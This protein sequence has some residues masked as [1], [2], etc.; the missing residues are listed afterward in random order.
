MRGWGLGCGAESCRSRVSVVGCKVFGFG[1]GVQ[2]QGLGLGFR[3]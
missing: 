1:L 2:V 3:V